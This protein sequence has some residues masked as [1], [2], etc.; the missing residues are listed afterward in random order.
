MGNNE[1]DDDGN[2]LELQVQSKD[3]AQV[4][5]A[6]FQLWLKNADFLHLTGV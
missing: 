6:Y 4:T 1:D 2:V 5:H 3:K